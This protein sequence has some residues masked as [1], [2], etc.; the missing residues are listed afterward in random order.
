[1]W[2][3]HAWIWHGYEVKGLE[4]I[5]DTGPA[6]IVYYHG[7]IPLDYY[8]LTAKCLLYK[9]RLTY[10]VGDRFLFKIPG[11]CSPMQYIC[12]QMN[13]NLNS[14]FLFP[15]T[16]GWTQMMKVLRVFP[17]SVSTC[18]KV[19]NEGNLLAISP[20]GVREGMP[21]MTISLSLSLVES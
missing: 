10:S 3:T 9:N 16:I 2:E 4:N 6:L 19:L 15:F 11:Q 13:L 5:P 1:M 18:V 12:L 8:Y 21:K 7:A 20:G 14:L 17:G